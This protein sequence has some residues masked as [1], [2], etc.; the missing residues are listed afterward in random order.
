MNFKNKKKFPG[1]Q[2]EKANDLQGREK[3]S[4]L[5]SDFSAATFNARRQ[6]DNVYQVL[7]KRKCDP[8]T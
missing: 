3:K 6:L 5:A 2:T 7:R 8:R 1:N 4:G